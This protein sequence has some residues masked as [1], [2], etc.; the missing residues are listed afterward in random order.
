MCALYYI[1]SVSPFI[2]SNTHYSDWFC[3]DSNQRHTDATQR[4]SLQ[5]SLLFWTPRL[6][7]QDC[8]KGQLTLMRWNFTNE[9]RNY[10]TNASIFFPT[11]RKIL[12][13]IHSTPQADLGHQVPIFPVMTDLILFP[14]L[15]PSLLCNAIHHQGLLDLTPSWRFALKPLVQAPFSEHSKL[16]KK[17]LSFP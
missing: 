1:L 6:L 13:P 12:K 7:C 5:A 15:P 11:K 16:R 9:D 17:C 2:Y 10:W 14:C 8:G 3:S 4:A